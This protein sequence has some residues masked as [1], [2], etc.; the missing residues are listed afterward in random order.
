MCDT[1]LLAL[2]ANSRPYDRNRY[3]RLFSQSIYGALKLYAAAG[4]IFSKKVST[5]Y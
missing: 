4:D 5:L 2:A 3:F 1:Y